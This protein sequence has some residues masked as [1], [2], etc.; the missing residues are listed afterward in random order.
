MSTFPPG[1]SEQTV[2]PKLAEVMEQPSQ[3][4][5]Q[6]KYSVRDP[7]DDEKKKLAQDELILKDC[8]ESN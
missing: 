5:S 2:P 7:E 4:E 3:S 8:V 6:L 1:L